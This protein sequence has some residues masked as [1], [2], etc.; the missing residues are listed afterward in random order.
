M[1]AATS[2]EIVKLLSDINQSGTTI[3]MATH[4]ADIVKSM[5]KRT[6][7]LD[8]GE[9]IKDHKREDKEKLSEA[10]SASGGEEQKKK[11][12]EAPE[13]EDKEEKEE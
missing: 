1:D 7:E 13:K 8:K 2:W 9:I 5:N 4:N 12:K 6:I 3:I 10:K 11:D